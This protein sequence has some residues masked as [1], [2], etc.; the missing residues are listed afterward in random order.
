MN[1]ISYILSNNIKSLFSEVVVIMATVSESFDVCGFAKEPTD[2]KLTFEQK[3]WRL[4]QILMFILTWIVEEITVNEG[5][6]QIRLFGSSV[7]C[8]LNDNPFIIKYG[9]DETIQRDIDIVCNKQS[10]NTCLMKLSEIG[11][12]KQLSSLNSSSSYSSLIYSSLNGRNINKI[13]KLNITVAKTGK[14][15]FSKFL[16]KMN[17]DKFELSIDIV[18]INLLHNKKLENIMSNWPIC[19]ISRRFTLFSTEGDMIDTQEI[20]SKE[21]N[22]GQTLGCL[23]E[24]FKMWFRF[25]NNGFNQTVDKYEVI[26]PI[27]EFK[28]N[29]KIGHTHRLKLIEKG[30]TYKLIHTPFELRCFT[31]KEINDAITTFKETGRETPNFTTIFYEMIYIRYNRKD[32]HGRDITQQRMM[33]SDERPKMVSMV[34]EQLKCCPIC[35]TTDKNSMKLILP[36][37][38][39]FCLSCIMPNMI[40]YCEMILNRHN[41]ISISTEDELTPSM[42]RC[43]CCRNDILINIH[44]GKLCS[45]PQICADKDIR[46]NFNE[47]PFLYRKF[48]R[49]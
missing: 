18:V 23:I 13:I 47:I 33:L 36:C 17:V 45:T 24:A 43:P 35:T 2:K 46:M 44:N 1:I 7:W 20:M 27:K 29:N 26:K 22:L 38:H 9:E 6:E 12:I 42:N 5:P 30:K 49:K 31:A 37:G 11:D 32:N 14:T 40:K 21:I 48:V 10:Y 4:N 41:G 19:D 34:E 28:Q 15:L 3:I 25:N 16:K 39:L 8:Y